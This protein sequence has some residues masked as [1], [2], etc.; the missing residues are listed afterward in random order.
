[1]ENFGKWKILNQ[2]QVIQQQPKRPPA[3]LGARAPISVWQ[4]ERGERTGTRSACSHRGAANWCLRWHR[5]VTEGC[6]TYKSWAELTRQ[7]LFWGFQ[8][9]AS[10]L[11]VLLALI[12]QKTCFPLILKRSVGWLSLG[13]FSL[14]WYIPPPIFKTSVPSVDLAAHCP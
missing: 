6:Q 5:S 12:I 10:R 2:C 13:L 9:S 8:L 1:M 11:A 7:K 3:V 14:W 4:R